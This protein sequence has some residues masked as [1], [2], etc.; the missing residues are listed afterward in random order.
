MDRVSSTDSLPDGVGETL[1]GKFE[2][3]C[4]HVL[5]AVF[6]HTLSTRWR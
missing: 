4:H 2:L 1:E 3:F 5:S 6:G